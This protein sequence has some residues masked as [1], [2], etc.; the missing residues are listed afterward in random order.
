MALTL[1]S[2]VKA[3]QAVLKEHSHLVHCYYPVAQTPLVLATSPVVTLL[4]HILPYF[5][6]LAF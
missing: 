4:M 3:A 6:K 1:G 5:Q 2:P